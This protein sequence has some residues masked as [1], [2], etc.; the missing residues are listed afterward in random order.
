MVFRFLGKGMQHSSCSISL[1]LQTNPAQ[2]TFAF[3]VFAL[4]KVFSQH[5]QAR[6]QRCISSRLWIY[7]AKKMAKYLKESIV[8]EPKSEE[9]GLQCCWYTFKARSPNGL[10]RCQDY[11]ARVDPSSRTWTRNVR[12]SEEVSL[13]GVLGLKKRLRTAENGNSFEQK[14]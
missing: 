12:L 9:K 13:I 5:G 14:K 7:T 10:Q 4:L 3:L 6:C 1:L 11:M 8:T 2:V